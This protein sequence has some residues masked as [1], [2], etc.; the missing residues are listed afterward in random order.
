[1]IICSKATE[2]K[3]NN[4]QVFGEIEETPKTLV[5][6]SSISGTPLNSTTIA[7][8]HEDSKFKKLLMKVNFEKKGT[9]TVEVP[10]FWELN[11]FGW[12]KKIVMYHQKYEW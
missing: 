4:F 12:N 3:N 1:M 6:Q 10:L 8:I 9:L 5:T 7:L 2:F 11:F